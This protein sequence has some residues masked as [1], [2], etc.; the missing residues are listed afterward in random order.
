MFV[1]VSSDFVPLF[2]K[3]RTTSSVALANKSSDRLEARDAE[4]KQKQKMMSEIYYTLW[5]KNFVTS[6]ESK[7]I[8]FF[9]MEWT[10]LAPH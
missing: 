10:G 9:Q 4:G 1:R 7:A 6:K 2:L 5:D 8:K 3:F